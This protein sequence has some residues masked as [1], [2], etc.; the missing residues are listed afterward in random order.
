MTSVWRRQTVT[1]EKGP[2]TGGSNLAGSFCAY[3]SSLPASL[4]CLPA[5]SLPQFNNFLEITQG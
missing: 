1:S 3:V 2:D 4:A 5:L